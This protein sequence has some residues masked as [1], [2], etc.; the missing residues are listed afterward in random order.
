[1]TSRWPTM[2]DMRMPALGTVL[3]KIAEQLAIRAR[4]LR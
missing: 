1:M 4:G 2:Q 3:L